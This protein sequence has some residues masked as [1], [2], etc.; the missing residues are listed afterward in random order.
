MTVRRKR[1]WLA[2]MALAGAAWFGGRTLF[3]GSSEALPVGDLD[4]APVGRSLLLARARLA[5]DLGPIDAF[6]A[7]QRRLTEREPGVAEHW[8]VLGE[9]LLERC[10]LRDHGQ[11][12]AVG[13]TVH[14]EALPEAN[15][16]D[17]EAGLAAVD[18]AIELGDPSGDVHRI[19]A[20]LVSVSAVGWLDVVQKRATVQ[21]SLAKAR[22]LEPGNPRLL[23]ALACERLFTPRLFGGD[24]AAAREAFLAVAGALEHDERPYLYAAM[25][26]HLLGETAAALAHLE[27]AQAR[28]PHSDYV[29]EVLR[30]IRAGEDDPFG[31]DL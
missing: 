26:S 2:A 5:S 10:L 16:R 1:T 6:V 19:R 7:E 17:I 18:R 11:G 29:R 15:A 20:A 13:E 28:N 9:A 4:A 25:A 14:S 3:D 27:R 30:R 21:A 8:R 23:M 24:P 12:M 31:R 22:E